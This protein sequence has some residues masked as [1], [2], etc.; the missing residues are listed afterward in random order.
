[1]VKGAGSDQPRGNAM[2]KLAHSV[3]IFWRL[4]RQLCV[5]DDPLAK[6]PNGPQEPVGPGHEGGTSS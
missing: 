3:P 1:V 2:T 4:V 6:E 5:S